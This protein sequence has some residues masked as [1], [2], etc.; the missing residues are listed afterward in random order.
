MKKTKM[1]RYAITYIPS[2]D[3][4]AINELKA[5][6]FIKKQYKKNTTIIRSTSPNAAMRKLS[7]RSYKV[8]TGR[9]L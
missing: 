2:K 6:Q 8:E 5:G 4:F 1:K 3:G 9:K 7:S